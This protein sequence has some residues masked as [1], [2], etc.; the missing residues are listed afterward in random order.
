MS[1][2]LIAIG[3]VELTSIAAGIEVS[4]LMLK[5]AEVNLVRA[6]PI[7]PGK[8]LAVVSGEVGSVRDAVAVAREA[9]GSHLVQ[10]EVISQVAPEVFPALTMSTE[11]SEIKA[12][13]VIETFSAASCLVAADAAV[14][15]A[16]VMLIEIRL[17]MGVAGKSFLT[18]TGDVD[19]TRDAVAAGV[20]AI[21]DVGGLLNAVV[22][23]GPHP[24]LKDRFY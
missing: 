3:I 19:P 16:P 8:Y 24:D 11:V 22:I 4:D 2:E 1:G 23:P 10:D 14:K 15:A 18:L 13:G 17:G 12:L 5:R 20:E 9:A 7:C 6:H 21:E